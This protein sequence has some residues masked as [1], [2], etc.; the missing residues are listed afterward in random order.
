[1][2]AARAL[3]LAVVCAAA[4]AGE[5]QARAG[6]A[7]VVTAWGMDDIPLVQPGTRFKAVAAGVELM[8][9]TTEGRIV[10]WSSNGGQEPPSLGP[11]AGIAAGDEHFLALMPDGTVVAWGEGTTV[12]PGLNGVIA[13]A[14]GGWNSVAGVGGPVLTPPAPQPG[15]PVQLTLNGIAG[16]R[17]TVSGLTDLVNW[18]PLTTFVATNGA[19]QIVDPAAGGFSHRFYRAT[20]P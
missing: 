15:G 17:Y 14:A 9:L 10:A 3:L 5:A 12:P 4:L 19:T 8:A 7:G 13:I 1:M 18:T 16:W 2:N 11:V 20:A 6:R